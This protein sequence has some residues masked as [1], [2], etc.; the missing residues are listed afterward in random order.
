[1]GAQ[2]YV[3]TFGIFKNGGTKEKEKSVLLSI[4]PREERKFEKAK[5][6][7]F[8]VTLMSYVGCPEKRRATKNVI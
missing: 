3:S 1:M 7:G 4:V 8:I 5:Q 6:E 2:P